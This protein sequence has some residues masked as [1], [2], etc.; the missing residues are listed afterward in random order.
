MVIICRLHYPVHTATPGRRE[1]GWWELLLQAG[2]LYNRKFPPNQTK[3]TLLTDC[4]LYICSFI[5]IKTGEKGATNIVVIVMKL[6]CCYQSQS[7]PKSKCVVIK[8]NVRFNN[9][10]ES[11]VE[12]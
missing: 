3:S 6:F 10:F 8:V 1:G 5:Q 11:K 2:W 4:A 7:N 12:M 9:S